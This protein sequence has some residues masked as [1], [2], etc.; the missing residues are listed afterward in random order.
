MYLSK[1]IRVSYFVCI[2]IFLLCLTGIHNA[3]AVVSSPDASFTVREYPTALPGDLFTDDA[4]GGSNDFYG[5]VSESTD[6]IGE[7]FVEFDI[8]GLSSIST[9]LNLDIFN[10]TE[11]HPTYGIDN[12]VSLATYV[13]TGLTDENAFGTGDPFDF[14]NLTV[15]GTN[16]FNVDVTTYFNDFKNNGYDYLGFRLYDPVFTGSDPLAGSQ[17]KFEGA[18]LTTVVPEPIS[19]AL[20]VV[21]G[22]LLVG[23]RYIKRKKAAF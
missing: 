5:W 1:C 6:V 3:E 10:N 20:F 8:S 11:V 18:T 13:G 22:T 16:S 14:V 15:E 21:G 4:A 7:H 12:T 17:V 19:S 9:I 23:R 2:F